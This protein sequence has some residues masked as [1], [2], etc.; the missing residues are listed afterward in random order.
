MKHIVELVLRALFSVSSY[1]VKQQYPHGV[2][3]E[4]YLNAN[5][6]VL[7]DTG[8]RAMVITLISRVRTLLVKRRLSNVNFGNIGVNCNK[9]L[10]TR[11]I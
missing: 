6:W 4:Q 5:D 7:I 1:L 9:S 11:R 3:H 10:S 8:F 2:Q